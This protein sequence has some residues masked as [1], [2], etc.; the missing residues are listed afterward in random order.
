MDFRVNEWAPG[1]IKGHVF[2]EGK[3]IPLKMMM[4]IVIIFNFEI[5]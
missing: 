3:M 1:I 5:F 4:T 2:W